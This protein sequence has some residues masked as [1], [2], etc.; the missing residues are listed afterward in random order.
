MPL[1]QLFFYI[2][3]ALLS[4]LILREGWNFLLEEIKTTR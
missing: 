1:L 2:C 3:F 4:S